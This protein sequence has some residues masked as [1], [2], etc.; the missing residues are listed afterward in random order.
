M[1]SHT[2]KRWLITITVLV[3][4]AVLFLYPTNYF[5]K[6]PGE[7][8]GAASYISVEN[9]DE[10]DTGEFRFTTVA[11][12]T[13]TPFLY[14]LGN[15]LPHQE[16]VAREEIYQ[17]EEDP[18]EYKT[19]Q[20]ELMDN[21]KFNAISVAFQQAD[22]P[23]EIRFKGLNV[24]NVL[25]D[26]AAD[27]KLQTGDTIVEF[28]GEVI[29]N[30]AQFVQLIDKMQKGEQVDIVVERD[31]ELVTETVTLTEIPKSDGKIGLGIT[32]TENQSIQTDPP[33]KMDTEDIG[34]PSAGL[35]F[36]LEILNQLLDEDIT[37]GYVI[38]GTGTMNADGSVGRIGGVEKKV[39]A[40]HNAG[41][42]YFLAPDDVIPKEAYE[43]NPMLQ[44][45]YE[46]AV[47]AVKK[48]D[49]DM[50]VVAVQTIDDAIEFLRQLEPK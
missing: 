46:Q 50:E 18:E 43:I 8:Y 16:V 20:L 1:I 17:P 24:L 38:A 13:A 10:D 33:V 42:Q 19:R 26:S 48:I 34:G 44:T 40:A 6:K 28:A 31:K 11:V 9:K 27:G 41:A 7:A 22:L 12:M 32:Y 39:V 5:V 36:T 4:A 45:N 3:T 35:M 37:K 14:A 23:Y 30:T 15:I 47:E 25:T 2:M 49:T 21:S 29:K